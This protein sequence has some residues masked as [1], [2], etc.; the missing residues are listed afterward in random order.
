MGKRLHN[1]KSPSDP[2][3]ADLKGLAA[4]Q[5]LPIQANLTLIRGVN[6]GEKVEDGGLA[7]PVGADQADN[8]PAGN[9]EA[10]V[11]DGSQAS[12]MFG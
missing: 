1:L 3:L 9:L 6:T 11:L 2:P 5:V 7:G 8:L 4:N 12:K 10:Y